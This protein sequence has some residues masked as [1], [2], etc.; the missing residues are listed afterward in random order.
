MAVSLAGCAGVQSPQPK[1]TS[2]PS[3]AASGV[4]GIAV[5]DI[6]CPVLEN[7]STCPQVPLQTRIIAVRAGSIEQVAVNDTRADGT[8]SIELAP[9]SYELRGADPAG[10]ALPVAV[11]VPVVVRSGEFTSVTVVFDSGVRVPR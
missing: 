8:F 9:G 10:A 2:S 1:A 11:P 6:G 3:M 4:R 7:S 5:V